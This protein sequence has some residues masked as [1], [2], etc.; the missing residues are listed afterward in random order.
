MEQYVEDSMSSK[1]IHTA[2]QVAGSIIGQQILAA[3]DP[4]EAFLQLY[5]QEAPT[6]PRESIAETMEQ[7]VE[8]EDRGDPVQQTVARAQKQHTGRFL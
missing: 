7:A 2:R 1:D 8:D 6:T 3:D 4:L 5:A